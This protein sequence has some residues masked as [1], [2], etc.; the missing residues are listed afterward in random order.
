MCSKR[1]KNYLE[2]KE[3]PGRGS[4]LCHV[5]TDHGRL[6]KAMLTDT[7]V[8]MRE[9]VNA[10]ARYDKQFN[11]AYRA[12]LDQKDDSYVMPD[13]EIVTIKESLVWKLYAKKHEE[14]AR[15]KAA[16]ANNGGNGTPVVSE[17]A[18]KELDPALAAVLKRSK[19]KILRCPKMSLK[20]DDKKCDESRT[21]G[22]SFRLHFFLHYRDQFLPRVSL[23]STLFI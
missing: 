2:K 9:E 14:K 3:Y 7:E 21:E 12:F 18:L 16:A 20:K 15:Q 4:S 19:P 23:F 13:N 11:E 22:Q 17:E 6:L 10:L 5:A 8:D 1:F